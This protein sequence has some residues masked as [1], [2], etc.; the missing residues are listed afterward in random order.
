[1]AALRFEGRMTAWNDDKG[2]GFATPDAG[3]QDI[4]VHVSACDPRNGRRLQVGDRVSFEVERNLQGKKRAR[5]VRLPEAPGTVP[6]APA[7]RRAPF[8][9]EGP[10]GRALE[11]T[12]LAGRHPA[13][14]SP[15]RTDHRRGGR[16]PA[17]EQ[18]RRRSGPRR[19]SNTAP[20]SSAAARWV[21][22]VFCILF[23]YAAWAW[24]MPGWV[25]ALYGGASVLSLLAYA[26]DKAAAQRGAWRTP[27][28]TLHVLALAGGWPGALLAQGWLRHKTVKAEF[29]AVFWTTVVFNIAAFL[30]VVSPQGLA[31]LQG[32]L[33]TR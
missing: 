11:P 9:T 26:M 1:M 15:S 18:A 16:A 21:F 31:W 24:K 19:M 20:A 30:L 3:D 8:A 28:N 25:P 14:P 10:R 2:F 29:R 6:F 17:P 12:G 4:F 13:P 32:V 22:P 33:N 5:A 23:L 27:E 7:A